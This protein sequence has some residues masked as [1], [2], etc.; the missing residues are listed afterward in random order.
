DE[1]TNYVLTVNVPAGQHTLK[2]WNPGL[3]WVNLGNLTLTPYVP[4]LGAYQVGNSN[5]AAVWFWHRTNVYYTNA[6]VSLP[7]T[8]P[9]SGLQPGSYE[10][11]WWDTFSG[12]AA[13]NFTFT[14]ADTNPVTMTTPA[15]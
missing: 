10:G 4:M 2:L 15:V 1:N 6:T 3:D 9:L 12:Q 5:F 8:F 11:V 14:V 13:N 7:G